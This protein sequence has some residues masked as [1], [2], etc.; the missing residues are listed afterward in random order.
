[1]KSSS[2]WLSRLL[3]LTMCVSL[4]VGCSL[5]QPRPRAEHLGTSGAALTSLVQTNFNQPTVTSVSFNSAQVAGNL[6]VVLVGWNLSDS[7]R[8]GT[9]TSVTDTAGN[10]YALAVGPTTLAS[11]GGHS[12]Y[13]AK[14]IVGSASNTVTVSFNMFIDYP[15]V[16]IAEYSGL[17]PAN[18]LDATAAA[19]GDGSP[20]NSGTL[21]TTA[22]NDLIVAGNYVQGGTTGPGSGFTSRM[23]TPDGDIVEDEIAPTAGSYSATAPTSSPSPNW[24]VMQAVA[25]RASGSPAFV[26]GNSATPQ[27]TSGAPLVSVT[28]PFTAAQ[29]AGDLNVVSI[30]WGDSTTTVTTVTDTAGNT[31]ALAVGPTSMSGGDG[32]NRNRSTTPRTSGRQAPTPTP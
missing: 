16:R 24:F 31:Y 9:V 30:G 1:M 27:S 22:A 32:L 6:N 25:F 17:D 8:Q 21:T 10:T 4:A 18:A 11:S 26:Q 29:T 19:T 5:N 15:D 3:V 12:I 14:N 7:H 13:Y 2:L 20:S 23:I 28:A